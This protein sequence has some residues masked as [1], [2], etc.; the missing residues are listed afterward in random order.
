[1]GAA[2]KSGYSLEEFSR[3]PELFELRKDPRYHKLVAKLS[4]TAQK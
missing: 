2:L 1:M 3:D 4:N